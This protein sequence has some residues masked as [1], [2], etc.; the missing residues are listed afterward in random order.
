MARR[1]GEGRAKAIN[2]R[3]SQAVAGKG[4]LNQEIPVTKTRIAGNT[5]NCHENTRKYM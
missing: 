2:G 4:Q 3:R 1:G 5:C